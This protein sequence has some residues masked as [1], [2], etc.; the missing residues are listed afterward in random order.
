[1]GTLSQGSGQRSAEGLMMLRECVRACVCV[2]AEDNNRLN[3]RVFITYMLISCGR[4]VFLS[5]S[6]AALTGVDL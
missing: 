4:H 6:H 3:W 5:L 1:M 2:A